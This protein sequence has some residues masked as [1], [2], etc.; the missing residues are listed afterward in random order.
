MYEYALSG[1]VFGL[2]F[3]QRVHCINVR[4]EGIMLS[5][6]DREELYGFDPSL[7]INVD[8]IEGETVAEQ[9]QK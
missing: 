9:A 6:K 1:T 2:N 4:S 3:A 7:R 5:A 8:L